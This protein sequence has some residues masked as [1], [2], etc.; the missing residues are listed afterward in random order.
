MLG[1]HQK[2]IE[3]QNWLKQI[4]F[5]DEAIEAIIWRK[6]I[7][8]FAWNDWYLYTW[9][10]EVFNID[11][12]EIIVSVAHVVGGQAENHVDGNLISVYDMNWTRMPII[13][14]YKDLEFDIWFI[15]PLASQNNAY[16]FWNTPSSQAIN[17][18]WI[19]NSKIQSVPQGNIWRV[20]EWLAKWFYDMAWE[21]INS[22]NQILIPD[23]IEHWE[24]W[25][26][27]IN[28]HWNPL[29][30]NQIWIAWVG[31]CANM[32]SVNDSYMQYKMLRL[33]EN[34]RKL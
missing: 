25:G 15:R 13:E 23:I 19:T 6:R 5:N 30:I 24:S 17:T 10:W 4:G 22:E 18:G 14:Y 28:E 34:C 32:K 2:R 9:T 31:I 3:I 16:I 11:G 1:V 20:Q 27:I 33:Q 21:P 29:C 26:V 7:I 8:F 12:S